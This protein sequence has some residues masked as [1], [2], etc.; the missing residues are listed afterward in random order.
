MAYSDKDLEL[1][2]SPEKQLE[3]LQKFVDEFDR[4][5][6]EKVKKHKKSKKSSEIKDLPPVDPLFRQPPN[7]KESKSGRVK[8]VTDENERI[9]YPTPDQIV[10]NGDMTMETTTLTIDFTN[11]PI[12]SYIN[13]SKPAVDVPYEECP[14]FNKKIRFV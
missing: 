7:E 3:L 12:S 6:T 13:G 1:F 5:Y 10:Q 8:Y 2:N 14:Y 11:G 9:P 4:E